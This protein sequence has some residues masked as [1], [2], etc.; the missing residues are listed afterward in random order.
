MSHPE[1]RS[2]AL[3]QL[4]QEGVHRAQSAG[5]SEAEVR[6][7]WSRDLEAHVQ[8]NDLD[9]VVST[10]ETRL[11]VRVVVDGRPGFATANRAEALPRAISDAIELA[12]ATAPDPYC[13]LPERGGELVGSHVDEALMTVQ[14]GDLARALLDRMAA[15][16]ARDPR[17][18]IDTAEMGVSVGATAIAS[19]KGV[20]GRFATTHGHGNVFGMAVDGDEVGSF[21]YDGDVVGTWEQ[22]GP[23]LAAADARFAADALGALGAQAGRSFRGAVLLPPQVFAGMLV[24]HLTGALCGDRIRQ[25][26]SPFAEQLNEAVAVAGLTVVDEGSGLPG[27]PLAPFDREGCARKRRVIVDNGVLKGFFYDTR[28]GLRAGVAST[29]SAQGSA[30][31]APSVGPG[32]LSVAPGTQTV[33][34]LESAGPCVVVTRFSGSTNA[35]SGDFS[36]V[37][38]GGFLSEGGVRRPIRETTIAGNVYACLQQITGLSKERRVIYG[39]GAYPWARVA[40]VSVTAG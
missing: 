30:S 17:L 1:A 18:T 26:R 25:G 3:L 33:A 8:Q 20:A 14:A 2:E 34:E 29:A 15:L 35:T 7:E 9:G 40:D 32:P 39:R 6:A 31:S 27:H 10:E 38:K 37:V 28:E 5:A 16:S 13:A 24:G 19:S 23:I 4:C 36:G 21:A 11:G 22:L 12:R